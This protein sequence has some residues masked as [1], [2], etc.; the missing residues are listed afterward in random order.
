MLIQYCLVIFNMFFW[1]VHKILYWVILIN[2]GVDLINLSSN[3]LI[4]CF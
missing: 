1:P 2:N 3:G 4:V